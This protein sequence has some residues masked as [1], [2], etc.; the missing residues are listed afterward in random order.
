M[1]IDKHLLGVAFITGLIGWVVASIT[2]LIVL[3]AMCPMRT[4]SIT[5]T[6]GNIDV[7]VTPIE[8]DDGYLTPTDV[9]GVTIGAWPLTAFVTYFIM[10]DRAAWREAEYN[11]RWEG[12]RRDIAAT[13]D[14]E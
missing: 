8:Y 3:V 4:Q 11:A 6:L 9:F 7:I 2:C 12:Y 1:Q 10:R 14:D 5:T 13:T